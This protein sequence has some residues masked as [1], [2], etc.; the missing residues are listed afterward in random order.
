MVGKVSL[1]FGNLGGLLQWVGEGVS[2]TESGQIL[3]F[4]ATMCFA[5]HLRVKGLRV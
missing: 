2:G 4:C 3:V 5:W 1:C